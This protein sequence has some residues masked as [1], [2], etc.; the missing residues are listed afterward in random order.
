MR[1]SVKVKYTFLLTG[2]EEKRLLG[3]MRRKCEGILK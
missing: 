3:R 2:A 1:D